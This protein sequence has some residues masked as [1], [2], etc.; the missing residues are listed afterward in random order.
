MLVKK[1]LAT[2]GGG[3]VLVI[4]GGGS[5]KVAL[6]GDR[7]AK[8]G[9]EQGWAG[10][11]INGCIRDSATIGTLPIG[12]RALGTCPIKPA[13]EDDGELGIRLMFASTIFR[14][15]SYLYADEDGIAISET[16]LE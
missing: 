5:H 10:L 6:L 13:M 1:I 15:G 14:P 2:E 7:L 12:I 3:R 11:I 4:D 8:L 9:L 16:R